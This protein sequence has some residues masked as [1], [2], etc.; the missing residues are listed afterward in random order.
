M[1]AAGGQLPLQLIALLLQGFDL[2]IFGEDDLGVFG[3]VFCLLLGQRL[4]QVISIL[5]VGRGTFR[6]LRQYKAQ[7]IQPST[8]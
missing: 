8:M 1:V 3:K 2:T 5:D 6:T 4:L 7:H